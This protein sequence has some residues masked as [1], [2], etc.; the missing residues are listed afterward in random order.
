M[1]IYAEFA[2]VT[3]AQ[4]KRVRDEFFTKDMLDPD[5]II[6]LETTLADAYAGKFIP[7]P[8]TKEQIAGL[9]QIQTPLK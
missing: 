9:I 6:G 8:M 5:R 4:A 7:S 2:K 3:E 1:T